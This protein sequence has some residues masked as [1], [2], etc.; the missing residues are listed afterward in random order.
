MGNHDYLAFPEL[1]EDI[2]NGY[3]KKFGERIHEEIS[4]SLRRCVVKFQV[5]DENGSHLIAQ[6]L[7]YCWSTVPGWV[8]T[9]ASNMCYDGKGLVIP[10]EAIQKVEF[11]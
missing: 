10:W 9:H 4:D 11:L 6:C 2:S 7:Q 3:E 8:L 1:V 5:P